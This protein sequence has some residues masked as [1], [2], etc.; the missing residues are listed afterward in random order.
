MLLDPPRI[1]SVMNK[2]TVVHQPAPPA[3]HIEQF[4]VFLFFASCIH[5]CACH[6]TCLGYSNNWIGREGTTRVSCHIRSLPT[7]GR[8]PGHRHFI[9]H[10][11]PRFPV[12][13]AAPF[14]AN[15]KGQ[16]PI[17]PT[18]RDARLSPLYIIQQ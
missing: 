9:S 11:P 10:V 15:A 4:F 13:R 1:F 18:D 3:R 2:G 16:S 12:V 5:A 14:N 6:D 8:L 7:W 17:V